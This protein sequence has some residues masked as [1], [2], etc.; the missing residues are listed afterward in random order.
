MAEATV[1]PKRA[2]G[3]VA[4]HEGATRSITTTISH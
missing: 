2:G 3:Y 4:E 1:E